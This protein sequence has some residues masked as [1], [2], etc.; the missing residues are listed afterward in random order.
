MPRNDTSSRPSSDTA[1]AVRRLRAPPGPGPVRPHQQPH[2]AVADVLSGLHPAEL[3]WI[4][5]K[6]GGPDWFLAAAAAVPLPEG[7]DDG[8]VRPLNDDELGKHP[9]PA[10]VLHAWLESPA[11]GE[12]LS[13]SGWTTADAAR[14]GGR[15]SPRP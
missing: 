2:T 10:T 5:E 3:A 13:G 4:A 14:D 8:V 1:T 11:T 6:A 7:E 15:P 12:I 9:D